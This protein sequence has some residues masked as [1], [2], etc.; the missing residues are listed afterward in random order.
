[1]KELLNPKS[2]NAKNEEM[3]KNIFQIPTTLVGILFSIKGI[4][5]NEENNL[6]KV[7]K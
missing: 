5:N 7:A 3:V 6:K 2:T 1:V 4:N